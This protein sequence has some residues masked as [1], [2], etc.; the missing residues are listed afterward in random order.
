MNL[1][2][3]GAMLLSIFIL[4]G[5]APVDFRVHAV[6]VACAHR[7][8]TLLNY[9][10]QMNVAL[11]MVHFPWLHLHI[12]GTGRYVR[13]RTHVVA[14]TKMPPFARGFHQIDLLG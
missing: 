11:K 10:F 9:T 4:G 8:P 12:G 13:G 14:F 7:N 2:P 1:K 5:S 6:E 3:A